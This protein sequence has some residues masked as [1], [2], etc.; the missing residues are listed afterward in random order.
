MH[1]FSSIHLSFLMGIISPA[2]DGPPL[3]WFKADHPLQRHKLFHI[4]LKVGFCGCLTTCTLFGLI[5]LPHCWRSFR[6]RVCF[7]FI[8]LLV[9]SWNTQM[10]VM[11]DGTDTELGPQ[12]APALFGYVIGVACAVSSFSCGRHVYDWM[13]SLHPPCEGVEYGQN[14]QNRITSIPEDLESCQSSGIDS[15]LSVLKEGFDILSKLYK[16]KYG[17]L[18]FTL[19]LFI[20]FAVVDAKQGLYFYREMWMVCLLAPF[21]AVL[22]WRISVFNKRNLRWA[23]GFMWIPWGTFFANIIA[24]IIAVVAESVNS[25]I[26]GAEDENFRWTSPLL[27]AIKV[28]FAGSLSTVSTLVRE[29]FSLDTA[30]QA[31]MYCLFSIV[32]AMLLGLLF[33]SPIIRYG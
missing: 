11:L 26:L 28:G 4:G 23:G 13:E 21:G 29:M 30:K 9:A 19:A 2:E 12:V 14:R 8:H 31:H 10:V 3:P 16:I 18:L 33:Y 27:T 20:T 17:P 32:T 25:R 6:S 5:L 22:R 15:Q 7:Y 24:V 1:D